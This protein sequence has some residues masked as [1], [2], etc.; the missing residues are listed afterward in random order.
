MN[1]HVSL[2]ISPG[3]SL[4][5]AR[6]RKEEIEANLADLYKKLSAYWPEPD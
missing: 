5:E 6:E 1:A 3:D 2:A 4:K